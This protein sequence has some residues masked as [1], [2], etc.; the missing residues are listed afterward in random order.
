MIYF[1]LAILHKDKTEEITGALNVDGAGN[2]EFSETLLF[3]SSS[4]LGLGTTVFS[5]GSHT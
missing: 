5:I 4:P 3:G 2:L 1:N